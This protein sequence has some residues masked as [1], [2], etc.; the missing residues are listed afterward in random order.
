M[1][2]ECDALIDAS[3]PSFAL[4][5]AERANRAGGGSNLNWGELGGMSPSGNKLVGI[6][7]VVAQCRFPHLSR[8]FSSA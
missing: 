7:I 1:R 5:R 2:F 8:K 6:K 3:I 4:A